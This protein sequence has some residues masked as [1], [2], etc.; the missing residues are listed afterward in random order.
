M[1]T[2]AAT[3]SELPTYV[4]AT[5]VS[6]EINSNNLED[7]KGSDIE[8]REA[9][10]SDDEVDMKPGI[11]WWQAAFSLVTVVI[12]AGVMALPNVPLKGGMVPSLF[13]LVACG[14]TITESGLTMWKGIMAGNKGAPVGKKNIVSYEDFGRAGFGQVGEASVTI[15]MVL[16]FIGV[17][18]SF[19]VL[20]AESLAHLLGHTVSAKMAL[21]YLSPAFGLLAMLPNVTAVAKLVPLAIIAIVALCSIIVLKSFMDAQRWQTWPDLEPEKLHKAWPSSPMNLGPVVAILFGSFSVNGN[22]PSVMCEMKDPMQF[23]L[24][25]KTA[26]GMVGMIYL[27]VMGACFYGYGEFTQSDIVDSLSY[28]PANQFQAFNEPFRKWTGG[29][30]AVLGNVMSVLLLVKLA[31]GLPLNLMVVFYS[32]QTFRYTKDYVPAGSAANKL[33][34]L[35]VVAL[36]VVVG[37]VVTNFSQLF[38]LVC[39]I[40]GPLLQTV[41]PLFFSYR[42]RR[43]RSMCLRQCV[44]YAM[45]VV[46][47]FTLTIGT[48]ESV[49]DIVGGH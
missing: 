18:S 30:A 48:Y 17:S 6:H 12:G 34:R 46:A 31:I 20:I 2:T 38:A 41:L 15:M 9:W 49:V 42:I 35:A 32:F 43:V 28:F 40:F 27:M 25:L 47:G 39:A 14:A 36:A 5:S 21:L 3:G 7:G 19:G 44:H 11:E 13:A 10:D 37:L 22:V 1:A 33:M 26:M 29:S 16:Y 45:L 24:A 4:P 23:P 8:T